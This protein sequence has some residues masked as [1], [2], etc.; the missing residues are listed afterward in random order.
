MGS[1]GT[2]VVDSVGSGRVE[3]EVIEEEM[4]AAARSRGES[5][6]S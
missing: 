2:T 4:K 3:H 1:G 5:L 6:S